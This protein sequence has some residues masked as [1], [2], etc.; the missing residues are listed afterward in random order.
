MRGA[1]GGGGLELDPL[2]GLD[3]PRM[4]LRSR[5]LAV[6]SLRA[7]YLEHVREIA[8]TSLHWKNLGPVVAQYRELIKD[9][10]ESDTRKLETFEAFERATSPRADSNPDQGRQISLRAFASQRRKFLLEYQ[11]PT[12][13]KRPTGASAGSRRPQ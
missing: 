11:E 13:E 7:K 8:E 1:R 10:V 5:L 9:D 4:P 3:D 12:G 6:P 2:I